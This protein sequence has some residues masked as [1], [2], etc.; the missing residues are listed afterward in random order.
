MT[1]VSNVS[2]YSPSMLFFGQQIENK[3]IFYT[4]L[5]VTLFL[6]SSG[7]VRNILNSFSGVKSAAVR[8]FFLL[9]RLSKWL[10]SSL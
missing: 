7:T 10:L 2:R 3:I 5:L 4:Y 1:P 9:F 8:F 6:H